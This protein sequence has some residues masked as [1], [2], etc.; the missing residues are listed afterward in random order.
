MTRAA[1]TDAA[2]ELFLERGYANVTVAQI[3][4]R[5]LVSV[6]T[7]FKY[8]PDGKPAII[9]D[10][11]TERRDAIVRAIRTREPGMTILE[12][13]RTFFAGRGPFD[14]SLEPDLER[15][16]GLI[17]ATPE[18]RDFQRQLWMRC[19]AP[20]VAAIAEETGRSPADVSVRALA[21]FVLA[22]PDIAG[23]D[24]DPRASLDVVIDQLAVGWS[25]DW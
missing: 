9:F 22:V 14:A 2:L 4:E 25:D 19:E 12:A 7:L 21:R 8:V 16:L 15:Q 20:L 13:L 11:G 17:L 24:A 18:L 10:D 5:A 1:L 23:M 6:A 3:A